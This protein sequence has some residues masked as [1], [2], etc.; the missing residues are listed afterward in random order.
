MTELRN[1]RGRKNSFSEEIEFALIESRC[2]LKAEGLRW[3]AARR[4][5]VADGADFQAEVRPVD[6]E[7]I[8][9]GK[10]L[11]DC[12]LWMCRP[13]S[14]CPSDFG[15]YEEAARC[16]ESL[17]SAVALVRL[18]LSETEMGEGVLGDALQLLAEAQ[19]AV[20]VSVAKFGGISD[21]DQ[22]EVFDWLRTTAGER[23]IFLERFMKS[24]DPADP[25]QAEEAAK[26]IE[27]MKGAFE[28]RLL[29]GRLR[30]KLLGKIRYEASQIAR[31]S[32]DRSE[33][34][35]T[36]AAA[37]DELVSNGMPPS[38]PEF[39]ELL[40]PIIDRLPDLAG[41]PRGFRLALREID[42]FMASRSCPGGRT[43]TQ[44]NGQPQ[45]L[46]NLLKGRSMVLIGGHGSPEAIKALE[47]RLRTFRTVL[48]RDERA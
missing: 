8:L 30:K 6:A 35:R 23:R 39:R 32:G 37:A 40:V 41:V 24:D 9:R 10:S 26:R 46:A 43:I 16:F 15:V 38:S 4:R 19:S 27:S 7:I 2:R 34:W 14:P 20:R 31:N 42:R 21:N 18:I 11:N 28:K 17:A 45:R 25:S 13:S 47:R 44:S 22:Q 29:E 12:Y 5:M 3:A 36:L 48:G 1:D 33:H